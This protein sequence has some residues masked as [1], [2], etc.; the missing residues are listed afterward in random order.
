[1]CE[2]TKVRVL[3]AEDDYLVGKEIAR[4]LKEIGHDQIG[5]ASTG[6]EALDL[7]CKLHPDV[8]LM[9]IAMPDLDGLE[10]TRRIQEACPTPV[11]VVSAHESQ[12]LVS[13][14]GE[15]G[16]GAYLTK[17]P[18]RR[19][20]ER[21]IIIA[22]AR[23]DDLMRIRKLCAGLEAQNRELEKAL[24]EI[25][26]LRGFVPICMYC[27][28]IRVGEGSWESVEINVEKRSE[29]TFSHGLCP[30]CKH[31]S[32]SFVHAELGRR[33]ITLGEHRDESGLVAS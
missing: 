27:K 3:V 33:E 16:V 22:I 1:M 14:A 13:K 10:A 30:D 19:E 11:V 2:P 26:T 28:K 23:H 6:V 15:V 5:R 32:P 4:E 17:P 9:D 29:A 12:D 8:V 25:K 21:A 24:A 18:T 20:I 31:L 7:V